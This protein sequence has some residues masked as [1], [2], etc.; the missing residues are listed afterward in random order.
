LMNPD[1]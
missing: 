1:R